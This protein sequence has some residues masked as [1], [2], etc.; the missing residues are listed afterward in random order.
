MRQ[1]SETEVEESYAFE[2]SFTAALPGIVARTYVLAASSQE[3]M[4]EWMRALSCATYNFARHMVIEL[5]AELDALSVGDTSPARERA[6]L[7]ALQNAVSD[8]L[9]SVSRPGVFNPNVQQDLLCKFDVAP[10]AS[11]VSSSGSRGVGHIR[12]F[13]EM[14]EDFGRRIRECASGGVTFCKP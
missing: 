14:H 2:L 9:K 5:Q 4:E 7:P 10:V 1:V 11:A 8:A 3:G 6:K 12:N 13:E